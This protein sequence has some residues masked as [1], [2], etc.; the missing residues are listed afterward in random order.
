[1]ELLLWIS[2]PL[3]G[4]LLGWLIRWIYAKFQLS[5]SEQLAE[6]LKRDAVKDAEALRKELILETKDELLKERN[7]QERELRE[8]RGELQRFEKR[9]LQKEENLE[10]K[11]ETGH[12][13]R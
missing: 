10:R 6:R 2:L 12:A 8:E 3:V 9:L 1:M 11:L 4:L 13:R 5:A 7:Q